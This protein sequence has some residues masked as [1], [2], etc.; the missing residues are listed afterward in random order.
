MQAACASHLLRIS[1]Y[2]FLFSSDRGYRLD[3]NDTSFAGYYGHRRCSAPKLS[4]LFFLLHYL[5][6]RFVLSRSRNSQTN[7]RSLGATRS[8]DTG[9]MYSTQMARDEGHN[10]HLPRARFTQST[11]VKNC[12]QFRER[13]VCRKNFSR[14]QPRMRV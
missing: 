7:E 11:R 3:S 12:R 5:P 6:P 2:A 1:K 13:T 8:T 4:Q 14:L 10:Y 9:S